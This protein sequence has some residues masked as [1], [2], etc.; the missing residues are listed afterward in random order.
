MSLPRFSYQAPSTLEE[1]V[2]LLAHHAG[3][4]RVIAGGTDL[5][6]K[7]ERR[8]LSPSALV[9]VRRIPELSGVRFSE[10][11]GLELGAAVCHAD[12]LT[13]AAL[14]R[15][16]PAMVEAAAWTA[17]VQIRNMATIGGNLCNGSPCADGVP[18]LVARGAQ[19]EIVGSAGRR[20]LAIEDLHRAPGTTSLAP[21]EI[22]CRVLVPPPPPNSG[23]AFEKLPA[24]TRIDVS[25]VNVAVTL[26]RSGDGC[27]DVRIVLGAVGPVP[28]R[29]RRAEARLEG[30]VLDRALVDEAG[31]LAA[32]DS[33]PISDV[34]ASAEYRRHIV[35][36]LTRRALG[37]A[38]QRAG[39]P[40]FQAASEMGLR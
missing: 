9:D 10:T 40:P 17:T 24:R 27:R 16:Y 3:A 14:R 22:L 28:L 34:R 19:L 39:L 8:Q 25:A 32:L 1:A 4:A 6:P 7:L 33:E 31:S 37:T 20:L 15:H 29:A 21:D 11:S 5:L 38:A 13:N 35:A 26:A 30:R 36:V 23:T 2:G 18:V 12:L